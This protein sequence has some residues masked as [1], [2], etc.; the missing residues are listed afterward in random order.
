M[1]AEVTSVMVIEDDTQLLQTITAKL[2][3][4]GIRTVSCVS[5]AQAIEYLKSLDELPTA[6]FVSYNLKHTNPLD[7]YAEI[8]ANNNWQHIPVGIATEYQDSGMVK[9]MLILGQQGYS[10]ISNKS[11]NE[12]VDIIKDLNT[13]E[14]NTFQ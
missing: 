2:S 8:Q 9:T 4:S 10:L 7:M 12:L 13:K 14:S 1:S 5:G 6:I 11:V 3:Q